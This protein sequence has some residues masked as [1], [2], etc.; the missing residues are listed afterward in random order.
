M[1]EKL[2]NYF[3][4]IWPAIIWSVIIFILLAMPPLTIASE[5]QFAFSQA[6]KIIHAILFGVLVVLWGFYLHPK[7]KLKSRFLSVVSGVV[8]LATMYGIAMEYVQLSV[9]RDF[10]TL[11]MIADGVGAALGGLIVMAIKNKPR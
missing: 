9:G 1:K 8:F 11:D 2:Q 6:D 4:T 7:Y 5:K 10:D 3:I